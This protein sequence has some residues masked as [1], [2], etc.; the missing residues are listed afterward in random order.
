[1]PD[2][3]I[4]TNRSSKKP[5]DDGSIMHHSNR[6]RSIALELHVQLNEA[7]RTIDLKSAHPEED[8]LDVYRGIFAQ[9][10]EY[11]QI[12]G[13]LLAQI[14]HAYDT[15]KSGPGEHAV[16]ESRLIEENAKLH[17]RLKGYQTAFE[18]AFADGAALRIK[19]QH[20][21][22]T[23]T[24]NEILMRDSKRTINQLRG[25]AYDDVP[26]SPSS[27]SSALH[28]QRRPRL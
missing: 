2:S 8:K 1:V 21:E 11:D 25:S 7:L 26:D 10:V 5:V 6:F 27:P 16:L 14:K 24:Q 20:L 28:P 22:A 15:A 18:K 4:I 23:N 19:N 12:F 9:V 13:G 17:K 3:A